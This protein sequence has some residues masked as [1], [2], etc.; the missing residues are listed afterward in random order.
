MDP[1]V[2]RLAVDVP[3]SAFEVDP[4]VHRV[5]LG[6]ARDV[7]ERQ[8]PVVGL[9]PQPCRSAGPPA[10]SSPTS[11]DRG[12]GA[13]PTAFTVP[14]VSTRTSPARSLASASLS[15]V[16]TTLTRSRTSLPSLPRTWIPPFGRAS[17]ARRPRGGQGGLPHLAVAGVLASAVLAAP[18]LVVDDAQVGRGQRRKRDEH[19]QGRERPGLNAWRTSSSSLRRPEWPEGWDASRGRRLR[20]PGGR[21]ARG[22]GR[23]AVGPVSARESRPSRR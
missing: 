3:A 6:V 19:G 16:A 4:A 14:V 15:P 23:P 21:R 9:E 20:A 2:D 7:L 18:A 13:G 22:P 12:S 5:Q 11:R 10:G 17:T 1:A 8:A